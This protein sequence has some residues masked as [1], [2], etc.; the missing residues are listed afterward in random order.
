VWVITYADVPWVRTLVP[1]Y[2][3]VDEV[4]AT[5]LETIDSTVSYFI[6]DITGEALFA[7]QIGI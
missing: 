1:N 6:D 3:G 7:D 2:G 4:P 5:A